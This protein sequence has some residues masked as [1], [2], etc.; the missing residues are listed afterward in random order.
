MIEIMLPHDVGYVPGTTLQGKNSNRGRAIVTR[1][2]EIQVSINDKYETRF[3]HVVCTDFGNTS[4]LT[5]P[6]LEEQYIICPEI[7]DVEQWLED[8]LA[9]IQVQTENELRYVHDPHYNPNRQTK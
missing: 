1:H 4:R 3:V 2:E 5:T 7:V 9:M 8:R 6:E